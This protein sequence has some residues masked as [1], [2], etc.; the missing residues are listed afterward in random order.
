M[1][2]TTIIL[3]LGLAVWL[4]ATAMQA[5]AQQKAVLQEARTKAIRSEAPEG[6]AVVKAGAYRLVSIVGEASAGARSGGLHAVQRG[7]A[8]GKAPQL[9]AEASPDLP[10]E[11]ALEANYPN[12][13]NPQTTIRFALPEAVQVRLH[14][15]DLLGREVARLIDTDM[16]AGRHDVVFNAQNLASGLYIYR[17]QAGSFSHHRTMLLVK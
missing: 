7:L 14:V 1:K 15:Y 12:P 5:Q 6:R 3:V 4:P 17:I 10:R 2:K 16:E 11:F 13:F 9:A 8:A